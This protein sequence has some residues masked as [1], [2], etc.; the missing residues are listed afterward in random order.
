MHIIR[1]IC[2]KN[3]TADVREFS[4]VTLRLCL[5]HSSLLIKSMRNPR[6]YADFIHYTQILSRIF[7]LNI[8]LTHNVIISYTYVKNICIYKNKNGGGQNG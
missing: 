8:Q 2:D 4:F 3:D 5:I 1:K 7:V 6:I